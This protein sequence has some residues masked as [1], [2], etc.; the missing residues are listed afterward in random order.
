MDATVISKDSEGRVWVR[1]VAKE[2]EVLEGYIK[3]PS[4]SNVNF[5]AQDFYAYLNVGDLIPLHIVDVDKCIF[6]ISDEF[7]D[8]IRNYRA[9]EAETL[10]AYINKITVDRGGRQ[11]A[12][13]WTEKGYAAQAYVFDD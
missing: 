2:Y 8:Y 10:S 3:S 11:K 13:M 4:L 9:V 12:Y 5:Y 6:D 1:T 7:K